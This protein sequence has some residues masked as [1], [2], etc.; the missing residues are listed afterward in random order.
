M[1]LIGVACLITFLALSSPNKQLS[2]GNNGS[3]SSQ[4][5]SFEIEKPKTSENWYL[6]SIVL[7]DGDATG[8]GA[9][10]WTWAWFQPWCYGNG[11]LADPYIIEN[12]SII[13][14][15]ASP[16]LTIRDSGKYFSITNITITNSN[17]NGNGLYILNVENGTI[18]D[19]NFLNN[20]NDGILITNTNFTALTDILATGNGDDGIHMT[21]SVMNTIDASNCSE[22][23]DDGIYMGNCTYNN[24]TS[25]YFQWNGEDGLYIEDSDLNVLI[26][27]ADDNNGTG[28]VLM[29]SDSCIVD[30]GEFWNNVMAGI[31]LA[32]D[33]GDTV[34][35]TI[36]DNLLS[37][38]G[39]NGADNST[40]T[41]DW[42]GNEWGDYP[43]YDGNDD[44]IGD[45]PYIS[46]N[47]E[48]DYPI[49]SDGPEP[50]VVLDEEDDVEDLFEDE[51]TVPKTIDSTTIVLI[52]AVGILCV[53]IVMLLYLGGVKPKIRNRGRKTIKSKNK[54][55]R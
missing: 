9:H 54:R 18:E 37:G 38:N 32:E 19:G 24:I 52:V 12:T 53:A 28:L 34:N 11:T 13:V 2:Q 39:I 25:S 30:N 16:G 42:D 14:N 20:G 45:L 8:V 4:G 1:F 3:R 48:D 35:N 50:L 6:T 23:T 10:N 46:G 51:K 31:L 27:E 15:S 47:I 49:F 22:N 40:G 55:K 7:I 26:I 36:T 41:N 21:W 17:A 43:Y 33:D 44:G 5:Q 29:D